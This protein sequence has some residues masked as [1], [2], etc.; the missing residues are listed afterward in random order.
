MDIRSEKLKSLYPNV[1]FGILKV[2]NFNPKN[3]EGFNKVKQSE[4]EKI[5][6]AFEN[7]LRADFVKSEPINYYVKFFKKLRK[8]M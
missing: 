4:I 8:L 2:K 5:S 3:S 1:Y 6:P 7:Y